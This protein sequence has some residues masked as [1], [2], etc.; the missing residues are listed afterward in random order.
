MDCR[1]PHRR[2]QREQLALVN[3][4]THETA[5]TACRTEKNATEWSKAKLKQLLAGIELAADGG[6][7]SANSVSSVAD[8]LAVGTCNTTEVSSIT[9]EASAK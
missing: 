8:A 7:W 6:T 5:L 9:G 2:H 4:T 3:R 1:G